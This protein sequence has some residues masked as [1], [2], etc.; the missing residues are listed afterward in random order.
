M[1]LPQPY[2]NAGQI[3][4]PATAGQQ[5][6]GMGE[7]K[8]RVGSGIVQQSVCVRALKVSL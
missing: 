3:A 1:A 6:P 2:T 8:G 4:Q 7:Q 5:L